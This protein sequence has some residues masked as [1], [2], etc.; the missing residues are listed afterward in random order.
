M[1]GKER[2]HEEEKGDSEGKE[3]GERS[4]KREEMGGSEK[5]EW[6]VNVTATKMRGGS[7]CQAQGGAQLQLSCWRPWY[8]PQPYEA[9][10]AIRLA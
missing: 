6:E 3:R 5:K 2:T 4:G 7:I 10:A 9:D 8:P 1:R